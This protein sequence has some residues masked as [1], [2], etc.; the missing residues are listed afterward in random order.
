[1]QFS[2]FRVQLYPKLRK[3]ACNYLLIIIILHKML[4]DVSRLLHEKWRYDRLSRSFIQA[5]L[6]T[7]LILEPF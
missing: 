3:K 5:I 7:F 2:H 4:I 6:T 1:M